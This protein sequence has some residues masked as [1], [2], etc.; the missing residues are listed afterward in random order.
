MPNFTDLLPVFI[1]GFIAAA[2][3]GY[4]SIRWLLGFLARGT[5]Y[6]FVVYCVVMALLVMLVTIVR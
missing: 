4:L 3:V 5:L 2:V 1:P 6:G